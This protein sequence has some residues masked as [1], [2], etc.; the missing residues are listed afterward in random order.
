MIGAVGENSE[1]IHHMWW[2]MTNRAIGWCV[3]Q[4]SRK[5]QIKWTR[6]PFVKGRSGYQ[7]FFNEISFSLVFSK[8]LTVRWRDFKPC[9]LPVKGTNVS[10]DGEKWMPRQR[11]R[12]KKMKECEQKSKKQCNHKS[13]RS[14]G[15]SYNLI[16]LRAVCGFW[17]MHPSFKNAPDMQ[18]INLSVK[19]HYHTCL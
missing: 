9:H 4:Y 17:C 1:C 5:G 8:S 2:S 19:R 11:E 7:F 3:M 10:L 6:L 14:M 16:P 18:A 13:Q 15:S 12:E